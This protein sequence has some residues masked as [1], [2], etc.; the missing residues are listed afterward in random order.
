MLRPQEVES[1]RVR[2]RTALAIAV[3]ATVYLA[4]TAA[5]FVTPGMWLPPPLTMFTSPLPAH[6]LALIAAAVA[7]QLVVTVAWARRATLRRRSVGLV[8]AVEVVI[9]AGIF[10]SAPVFRGSGGPPEPG[11]EPIYGTPAWMFWGLLCLSVVGLL[12]IVAVIVHGP[13]SRQPA[14]TAGPLPVA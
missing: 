4:V 12:M 9:G 14:G 11:S 3:G 2:R 1:M 8:A 10:V 5:I 6:V 13:S 7:L